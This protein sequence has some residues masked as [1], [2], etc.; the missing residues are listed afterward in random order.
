[1]RRLVVCLAFGIVL[2]TVP[3]AV[4]AS[5]T[6]RLTLI[7]ALRGCHVWATSDSRPFG[8]AHTVVLKPGGKI[9]IRI[10]CPM[11]FNVT[12]LAG[13]KLVLGATPWQSGTAHTLVFAK[14]GVYRL[15]A[16]N[17]QTS[18]ELNLQTLGPDNMP[19][20]TVRVN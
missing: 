18:E 14:R 16:M 1:M 19:V 3:T 2:V 11:A 7:H 8:P 12:Q 5:P 4:A 20:L 17:V 15:M 6:V 10:N 13:P 9:E